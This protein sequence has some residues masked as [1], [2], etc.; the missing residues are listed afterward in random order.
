MSPVGVSSS[1]STSE[2]SSSGVVAAEEPDVSFRETL[3][4]EDPQEASEAVDT[5]TSVLTSSMDESTSAC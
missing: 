2:S 1:S 3:R 4:R 5:L